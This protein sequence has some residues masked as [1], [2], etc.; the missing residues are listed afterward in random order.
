M[1]NRVPASASSGSGDGGI[2][3]IL[4]KFDIP[5][6]AA[7]EN[8]LREAASIW[9]QLA[10]SIRDTYGQANSAASS[11]TSNNE[12]AAIEAFEQYWQKYG[13]KKG[14]LPLAANACDAMSTA[15]TKYAD[16]VATTKSKIEEAA[17]EIGAVLVVGTIGAF[18]TF[19]AT[20]ALADSIAAGVVATA[21]EAITNLGLWV[22][23]TIEVYS[24]TLAEAIDSATIVVA[25]A[26]GS[27]LSAG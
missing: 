27:S 22:A 14:A 4:R 20:E 16:D 25:D 7:D 8:S 17:A 23:D 1:A 19:G 21:S 15:C 13:G 9:H 2:G 24:T 10:E 26:A 11:L 18:F 3:A 6:P 12:G 5:W